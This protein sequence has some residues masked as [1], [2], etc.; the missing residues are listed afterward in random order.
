M[1]VNKR[2]IFLGTSVHRWNDTR[3]FHKQA[4]SLAKKYDVEL[5]EMVCK[6]FE[7]SRLQTYEHLELMNKEELKTILEMYGLDKKK[8]KRLCK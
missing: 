2:S 6:H 5:V 7:C 8:I 1:S 3:I 4:T